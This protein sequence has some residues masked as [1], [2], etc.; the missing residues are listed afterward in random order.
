[1]ASKS[2]KRSVTVKGYRAKP[3]SGNLG[4]ATKAAKE[5]LDSTVS[6]GRLKQQQT[7]DSNND[8]L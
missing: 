1:M 6:L 2:E 7:T 3:Q 5:L 8:L 4:Q